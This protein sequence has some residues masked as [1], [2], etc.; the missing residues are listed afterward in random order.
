ME[1]TDSKPTAQGLAHG[2]RLAILIAGGTIGLVVTVVGLAL[3]YAWWSDLYTWLEVAGDRKGGGKVLLVL[4][5]ILGGTAI[6]FLAL[7]AARAEERQNVVLRRILYGYNAFLT[8][9]LV[10]LNLLVF[11]CLVSARTTRPLDFTATQLFTLSP[12]SENILAN[13][14]EPVS[15]YVI[16]VPFPQQQYGN[17]DLV[18]NMRQ[19]LINAQQHT[20]KII[21]KP[22][23]FLD[24]TERESV[25]LL[26]DMAQSYPDIIQNLGGG[27][28]QAREGVLVV[29]NEGQSNKDHRFIPA[30]D[31]F[32]SERGGRGGS[33]G[34]QFKGEDALMTELSFLTAEQKKTIVYFTQGNG[35]PSLKVMQDS[36][37]EQ[38]LGQFQRR[39]EKRNFEFRPLELKQG[40]AVPA[41]ANLVVVPGPRETLPEHTV[42]ALRDYLG[43]QGKLVAFL[44][45]NLDL[46]GRPIPSGLE[47]LIQERGI[48]VKNERV[49]SLSRF[50]SLVFC[51]MKT[52]T[53]NPLAAALARGRFLLEGARP[54]EAL[55]ARMPGAPLCEP[56]LDSRGPVLVD[57]DLRTP[58]TLL[59][60]NLGERGLSERATERPIPLAVI[61]ADPVFDPADPHRGMMGPSSQK[62]RLIVFG[63]SSL[64]HNRFIEETT[65]I[66]NNNF[67]LISSTFD[68]L[69]ERSTGLGIQPKTH[70]VFTIS[71]GLGL[72]RL[73]ALPAVIML[74]AIA[75]L[76][77][78]VWLIRRR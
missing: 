72:G 9:L 70:A 6:A 38:G 24:P 7:Q 56:L 20:D 2:Q 4:A 69:R 62:P 14:K 11:N 23:M 16:L 35:E 74:L 25:E 47:E 46:S 59:F 60:R 71:P 27:I 39:M 75:A 29:Y 73:V 40:Q 48:F 21:S 1:S 49:L 54:V 41:D 52:G 13:L 3:G 61:S 31:L 63:S 32:I 18:A 36:R 15:V 77:T 44:D 17:L 68:W 26:M 8:G 78:G 55:P 43:K 22:Q 42:K 45:L 53:S 33:Q 30:N 65:P 50:P 34:A 58:P 67:D 37:Q 64:I 57:T 66:P 5:A 76:G 12:S 19:L 28:V 10:F 51:G